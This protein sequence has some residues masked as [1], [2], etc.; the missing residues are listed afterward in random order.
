MKKI[1]SLAALIAAVSVVHGQPI[2]VGGS[3]AAQN[4]TPNIATLPLDWHR[5]SFDAAKVYGANVN[6]AMEAL[7]GRTPSK[8][9]TVAIIGT[10]FDAEHE[11]LV[12]NLWVN[13]GEIVGDGID[14]DGN[15]YVDDI[16]GWNFLG[17][18]D[19]S[20]ISRTS[21]EVDR[22]FI[23]HKERYDSLTA[24]KP[25]TAADEA[26]LKALTA[27]FRQ[28]MM[29]DSYV[30]LNLA[31]ATLP[32]Y[33]EINKWM[34]E[35]IAE[36]E[37]RNQDSFIPL[38]NSI[39]TDTDTV[40]LTAYSLAFYMLHDKVWGDVYP[41]NQ[42]FITDTEKDYD[43]LRAIFADDRAQ[44]GDNLLDSADRIYGNN[45]L[46]TVSQGNGT[47]MAGVIGAV[48][49]N[50]LGIDGVAPNVAL[51]LIR[52]IPAG[53]EY[54]K[55]VAVAIRYAVD[56]GADIIDMGFGKSFSP[57][58]AM[59]VQA[60]EYAASKNVLVVHGAGDNSLDTDKNKLWPLGVDAEGKRLPN[61]LRVGASQ[62]DGNMTPTANY[63]LKT[64][65]IFAPGAEIYTTVN[66]DN[67]LRRNGSAMAASVVAG[68]GALVWSYFPA[69]SAEQLR[70]VLVLSATT[71][72]GESTIVSWDQMSTNPNISKPY[73]EV[74]AGGGILNALEAVRL[75][76][77]AQP[78]AAVQT[79]LAIF[80]PERESAMIDSAL[81]HLA[82]PEGNPA[83][84]LSGAGSAVFEGFRTMWQGWSVGDNDALI[85]GLSAM[86]AAA[87]NPSD[88]N[89]W[90]V[91]NRVLDNVLATGTLAQ[92]QAVIAAI[93][94]AGEAKAQL[95]RKRTLFAGKQTL[96]EQ[97]LD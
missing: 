66:S 32:Y 3:P 46:F 56:N 37:A 93:D 87:P 45:N 19:G 64:V 57:H 50:G 59:V 30:G 12:A 29:G 55:D 34:V 61:Y 79:E 1:I 9:V 11:D 2:I 23:S 91:T 42:R 17:R 36:P 41:V 8:K 67:Y 7:H 95:A 63:G 4:P 68:V 81:N 52:A 62:P 58:A 77:A 51:M 76:E 14:N 28:S 33:D 13:K 10:G 21:L 53:D 80:N 48:Q 96:I 88:R 85:G 22:Y 92:T 25:R 65:D 54:D 31:H 40:R 60:L 78:V 86:L 24:K 94:G 90:S 69:L 16:N 43:G 39:R 47:R 71:R 18:A 84:R 74:S 20:Q 75:A 70:D 35:N 73:T 38:M 44:I 5:L 82:W 27:I 6:R 49:G 97:G 26:E 83:P 72:N 89:L 15:G